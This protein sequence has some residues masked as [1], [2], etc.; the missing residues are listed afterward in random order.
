MK[1]LFKL[2]ENNVTFR[3]EMLAALT[4]F[5]AAAYIIIVNASILSDSGMNINPLII[6]TVFTS[7]VGCLLVAFISNTPLIIVPG[8]GINALF[9]YTLVQTLGLSFYEALTSVFI[10]GILF[11]IIAITP[12]STILVRAIPNNLKESITIGI[13]LFITFIGLQKSKLIVSDTTTLLKLGDLT[14]PEVLAFIIIMILTL[15]LFLKKVPGS[16]LISIILGTMISV[17]FGI[18][19]IHNVTYSMP[20]FNNYKDIFFHL[21]FASLGKI[22]FWIG[23]FS[24]TLV[25]VFENIGII[26]SQVAGMLNRSEAASKA[27]IAVSFSTIT[28]ALLGSSP[29]VSAVEGTAGISAGGKTGLTSLAAGILFLVSIFFIPLISL[30]PNAAIAPILIILGC[31]M[32]QNLRNLNFDDFSELIPSFITII[33]IPLT[34]SIID[35]IAF[36]FILYPICK[37]CNKKDK[38]LSISMYITPLIFLLYFIANSFMH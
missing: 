4:S 30:I 8:M 15:V 7:V 3:S 36:G 35:G 38:Q 33:S 20:D 9:T 28:S 14:S 2:Q 19:D 16:F 31:L 6:A 10:A 11:V 26:Q 1:K 37:L 32:A 12:L 21:D 29:T 22:K 5:F 17:C 25:L 27:L 34:Y 23:T 18:I 24:L 13:G